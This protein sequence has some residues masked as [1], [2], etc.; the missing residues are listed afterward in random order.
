MKTYLTSIGNYQIVQKLGR[1]GMADV[2]LATDVTL[3]RQ[4]ALK[5]VEAGPDPDSREVVAAERLGAQLQQE[6]GKLDERVPRIHS[7]GE[8]EG[9]FYIDMEYVHGRDLWEVI[10]GGVDAAEAV[11]IA[12]EICSVL[13]NAHSCAVR[14]EEKELRAIVH[15]DIKPKNIRLETTGR[16]RVLDFGIAKGLSLTRKLTSNFFGSVSY[17][18][19]ERLETGQMDEMSDLWAV[20]VVL[21]EMIDGQLPFDA[22]ST[23]GLERAL[24]A[25]AAARPLPPTVP[26]A[27]R[28]I[29]FKALAPSAAQRYRSAAEFKEDLEAFLAGAPTKASLE[30]EQTRRTE[31]SDEETRRTD[32]AAVPIAPAPAPQ[33]VP[34]TSPATGRRSRRLKIALAIGIPTLFLVLALW[35]IS[36]YSTALDLHRRFSAERIDPDLAWSEYE[37]VRRRSLLGLAPAILRAPLGAILYE[38]CEAVA[39]EYRNNDAPRAREGDWIRCRRYMSR[40]RQ[41][42]SSDRR[43]AAMYEYAEGHVLRINRKDREAIAA[44]QR[45]ANLQSRWPDPYL[46]MARAYIYGLKDFDRGADALHRAE[47]LGHR[48]GKR[49][50]AQHADAYRSRALQYRDSALRLRGSEQEEDLLERA[51]DELKEAVRLYSEIAPWGDTMNQIRAAQDNLRQIEDRLDAL[52]PPNPLFPWNWLKRDN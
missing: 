37:S 41:L 7:F 15:G 2:Y 12:G 4:V 17:S 43:A 42:N 39:G 51:R 26:E 25:R 36:A 50:I 16:V 9:Y 47:E 11:R 22:A 31:R 20:G 24:R 49:E 32:A 23:E 19:P 3:G 14:I 6:L 18:S 5:L 40:L 34:T 52:N 45:A 33:A 44:F 48:P 46:G 8:L 13:A 21:Y 1:G 30:C 10:R 28:Q 29:V 35:E 38:G 27:L